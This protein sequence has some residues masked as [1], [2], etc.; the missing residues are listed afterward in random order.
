MELLG[1]EG[2]APATL[3]RWS[4]ASLELFWGRPTP[5]RQ[6]ELAELVGEFHRWLTVTVSDGAARPGS[7]VRAL[8]EH[9]LPD[10][11]RLDVETAVAAC[12]FVFIAGQSTTGQLIATVLRHALS[13]P[14]LWARAA[15]EDDLA[16]AWVEEVLRREPP[17]TSWRR[18]TASPVELGGVRLP[19]GAQLLLLLLGS[20]SDPE[21]FDA[22]ERMCPHRAN[23]RQHLAFGVGRHRCPGASLARTEAAVAL[24][25]AARGLPSARLDASADAP[26]LGLLSFRAPLRV[27]VER[28]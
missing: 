25:A 10:G 19:E 7:F 22:P 16:R 14:G 26:M 1:I 6:L 13:E 9:R 20:G 27:T 23:V 4:D 5:E 3:I 8:T 11:E 24:R 28:A 17:V 2:V 21:V 18:V 12:F 15:A